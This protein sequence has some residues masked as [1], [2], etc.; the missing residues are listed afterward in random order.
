VLA[1]SFGVVPLAIPIAVLAGIPFSA[2]VSPIV[3]PI[4][5]LL[6]LLAYPLAFIIWLASIILRPVA[7]PLGEAMD[8]IGRNI[9][10]I[11]ANEEGTR[12]VATIAA[13]LIAL[14]TVLVI[15]LIVYLAARWVVSRGRGPEEEGD[16]T[17][18]DVERTIVMPEPAPHVAAPRRRRLGP[19]RD[20]VTAYLAALTALEGRPFAR[21]LSETPADHAARV[22]REQMPGAPDMRRLAAGYQVARYGERTITRRENSRALDRLR[23]LRQLLRA[24]RA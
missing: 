17:T 18:A 23:R 5:W 9:L 3:G 4:Q 12:E 14:A 6:S 21:Q 11:P 2:I 22:T 19:A 16:P 10:E 20:A 13:A 7:G 1:I 24:A 8:L 15:A